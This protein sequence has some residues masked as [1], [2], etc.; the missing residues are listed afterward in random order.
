MNSRVG[1]VLCLQ[2]HPMEEPILIHL[3]S[4]NVIPF[5]ENYD[6]ERVLFLA[7][8]TTPEY[9][10]FER[11]FIEAMKIQ[12]ADVLFAVLNEDVDEFLLVLDELKLAKEDLPAVCYM[13]IG[14]DLHVCPLVESSIGYI[15]WVLRSLIDGES[16]ES[17]NETGDSMENDDEIETALEEILEEQDD[18]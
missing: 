1:P 16:D 13:G 9:D 2:L 14:E 10:S 3:N 7:D 8:S 4:E 5:L 11:S 15:E 6:Q 12:R 18:D 17:G